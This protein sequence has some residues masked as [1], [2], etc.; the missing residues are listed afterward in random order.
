VRDLELRARHALI[1][2]H[3]VR[4]EVIQK[5]KFVCAAFENPLKPYDELYTCSDAEMVGNSQCQ[6]IARDGNA[7]LLAPESKD[8]L[9]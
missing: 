7:S 6:R 3:D 9:H 1:A 2:F 8:H 5:N 4:I